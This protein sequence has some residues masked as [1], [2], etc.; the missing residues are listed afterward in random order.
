MFWEVCG[1]FRKRGLAGASG[2]LEMVLAPLPVL[3]VL[4]L[5]AHSHSLQ[6][7]AAVLYSP[8]WLASLQAVSANEPSS[9][10]LLLVKELL[11]T[12]G[13]VA[14]LPR[15]HL[16]FLFLFKILCMSALSV[17]ASECQRRASDHIIG[18]FPSGI[19]L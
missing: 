11:I 10:Q 2:L 19:I 8:W 9:L 14:K 18:D 6:L 16:G 3:S 4:F 17:C 15:V 13:K 7:P 12:M 5:A 1:T